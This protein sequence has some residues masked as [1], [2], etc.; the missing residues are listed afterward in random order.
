[1]LKAREAPQSKSPEHSCHTH[2]SAGRSK[3]PLPILAKKGRLVTTAKTPHWDPGSDSE[4]LTC[5]CCPRE[6][7]QKVEGIALRPNLAAPPLNA[8]PLNPPGKENQPQLR[9]VWGF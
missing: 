8:L 5:P 6:K 3:S 4:S 9:P 2:I 1:M 7:P